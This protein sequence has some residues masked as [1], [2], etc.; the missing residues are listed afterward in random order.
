MD[1]DIWILILKSA[2]GDESQYKEAIGRKIVFHPQRIKL[3]SL[4]EVIVRCAS[5]FAAAML[6]RP[7]FHPKDYSLEWLFNIKIASHLDI[8][9][10]EE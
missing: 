6:N 4:H 10:N 3:G 9:R 2:T 1:A 5:R 8:R 7:D